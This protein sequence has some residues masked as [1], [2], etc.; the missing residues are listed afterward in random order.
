MKRWSLS[1]AT[2]VLLLASAGAAVPAD[3]PSRP[4]AYCPFPKQG[5][6]PECF[7]D[8]E[9]EYPDFVAAVDS[10]EVDSEPVKD[11]ER[12][13]QAGSTGS[14]RTLALS[15]LAYGYF[16]L[17]ERA[18]AAERPDPAL[19]ARLQSWNELLGRVY[20]GADAD[21]GFRLAVRDAAQD[22]HSRAPAVDADC[23][24]DA[25]GRPCQTTGLLLKTLRSL[26]DPAHPSGVR[27]ALEHLLGRML[28]HDGA[29]EQAAAD[30]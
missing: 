20:E 17:A 11:V 12:A 15:S 26:D 27:G 23:E 13:L 5:E 18:A 9:R 1:G 4:G 25:D 24:P 3:D 19:V 2:I 29:G 30:E 10:G 28:P 8:V 7:A 16:R 21:S 14:A 22:L 6:V